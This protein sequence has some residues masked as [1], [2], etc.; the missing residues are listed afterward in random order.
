[1]LAGLRA[2]VAFGAIAMAVTTVAACAPRETSADI[3][4]AKGNAAVEAAM[5]EAQTTLGG[6]WTKFDEKPAEISDYTIKVAIKTEGGGTEYLWSEPIG[7]SPTEVVARLENDPVYLPDLQYGS[8][9]RVAPAQI[10]DWAYEKTGKL[11][12][13]FTTR[14]L[15]PGMTPPQ[16]AQVEPLL[17]PTPL[18]PT[19]P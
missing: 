7:H 12:G 19:A 10:V 15:L 4:E 13:H 3:I 17:A 5:V 11:Y 9:V 14:A 2:A 16:R 8:T 6:F 18:E 1:M